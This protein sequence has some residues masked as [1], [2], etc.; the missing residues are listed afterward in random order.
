M[1]TKDKVEELLDANGISWEEVVDV[2]VHIGYVRVPVDYAMN[3][4]MVFG[5]M[6]EQDNE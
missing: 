1:W 3:E 2:L 4:Q 5:F 6:E